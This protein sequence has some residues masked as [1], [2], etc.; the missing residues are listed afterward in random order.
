MKVFIE[1]DNFTPCNITHIEF[2][3]VFKQHYRSG[4]N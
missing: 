2:K 3:G 1:S 4:Q